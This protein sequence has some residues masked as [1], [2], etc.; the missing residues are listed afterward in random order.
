MRDGAGNAVCSGDARRGVLSTGYG[1]PADAAA[2]SD[3][4]VAADCNPAPYRNAH[5][6]AHRN[7]NAG[8]DSTIFSVGRAD[9]VSA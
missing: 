2:K 5:R 1:P 9:Y 8:A 7:A 3:G 4:H 6:N